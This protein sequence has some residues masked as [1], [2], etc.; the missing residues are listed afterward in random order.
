[1]TLTREQHR[2]FGHKKEKSEIL[3]PVKVSFRNP[4]LFRLAKATFCY[5]FVHLFVFIVVIAPVI[6]SVMLLV[7]IMIIIWLKIQNQ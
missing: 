5:I 1:M 4:V 3:E 6:N 7:V 2:Q